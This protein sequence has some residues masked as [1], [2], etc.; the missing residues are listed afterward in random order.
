MPRRPGGI[1]PRRLD[2]NAYR[3]ALQNKYLDLVFRRFASRLG[4][5][6]AVE[7]VWSALAAGLRATEA[8]PQNGVPTDLI[9]EHLE[10][11]NGYHRERLIQTFRSA[12]GVNVG[13]FLLSDRVADFMSQKVADNVGLI[14]TI[15]KR[16][17][18][19]LVKRVRQELVDAPFDQERLF[20]L[21]RDEY[22]VSGYN[23]RRIVRDQTSK[24]IAGLTEIR[25]TELGI[26]QY[27]WA[28]AGDERVRDTHAVNNGKAFSWSSPPDTGHPGSEVLC[29]CIAMP[30]LTPANATRLTEGAKVA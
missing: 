14:K 22:K 10:R 11:I 9:R 1:R 5:V 15:P 16:A 7:Q 29:R 6:A 17:H 21:Y 4:E 23:L 19:G 18:D 13:P 26:V 28:T 20:K 30:I 2:E 27:E 12:L 3:A 25:Q 8:L 24:T